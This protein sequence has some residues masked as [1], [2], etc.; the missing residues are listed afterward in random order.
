MPLA[1]ILAPQLAK[2]LQDI[3]ADIG[4]PGAGYLTRGEPG[5]DVGPAMVARAP[6]L[7]IGPAR[8]EPQLDIGPAVVAQP[9]AGGHGYLQ[10]ADPAISVQRAGAPLTEGSAGNNMGNTAHAVPYDTAQ[11][12]S[13]GLGTFKHGLPEQWYADTRKQLAD[14]AGNGADAKYLERNLTPDQLGYLMGMDTGHG[15]PIAAIPTDVSGGAQH[16]GVLRRSDIEEMT[17]KNSPDA[18]EG[19]IQALT[20]EE[21]QKATG[22]TTTGRAAAHVLAQSAHLNPSYL[23]SA[24]LAQSVSAGDRWPFYDS[25]VNQKVVNDFRNMTAQEAFAKMTENARARTF[26]ALPPRPA[27]Y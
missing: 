22:T 1:S 11:Q 5:L 18:S 12:R 3:E 2:K 24:D 8:V 6:G 17:R 14:P 21:W 19:A 15:H 10:L 23:S 4:P 9:M 13:L 26:G 20:D 25:S 7:D 16:D 27:D